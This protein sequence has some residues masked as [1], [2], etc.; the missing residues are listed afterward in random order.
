MATSGSI[1][2]SEVSEHTAVLTKR[3]PRHWWANCRRRVY[4]GDPYRAWSMPALRSHPGA[5]PGGAGRSG[6]GG[7]A[8][9]FTYRCGARRAAG[10]GTRLSYRGSPTATTGQGKAHDKQAQSHD[11][12]RQR[13][14]QARLD[15]GADCERADRPMR[16]HARSRVLA[17]ELGE[18]FLKAQE[19]RPRKVEKRKAP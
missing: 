16:C 8:V 5:R 1:S 10:P 18:E 3:R 12:Q 17:A 13:A 6:A 14:V 4:A 19:R 2:L 9:E 15:V 11:A 7:C